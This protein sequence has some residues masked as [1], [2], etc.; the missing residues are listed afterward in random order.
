VTTTS[1]SSPATA[2]T[3]PTSVGAPF[4]QWSVRKLVAHLARNTEQAVQIGRERLRQILREHH[5]S[6]QRTRTWK[7]SR[8]PDKD[9]K[10][11][12]IDYVITHF[13][14]P[15]LRVRPVRPTVDP[16]V[17]RLH[18]GAR[19]EAA[20]VA[21]DLPHA[22][23]S[24]L[25]RLL[26][27]TCRRTRPPRSDRGR[28]Q[29]RRAVSDPDLGVVGEPDRGPVRAATHLHDG[30]VRPSQP[31]HARPRDA[32]LPAVAQRQ[33]P[34]PRRPGRATP[35]THPHPQR[36]PP[37]LGPTTRGLTPSTFMVNAL[38]EQRSARLAGRRRSE[39]ADPASSR[40]PT[41]MGSCSPRTTRPRGSRDSFAAYPAWSRS[42]C[43]GMWRLRCAACYLR[44]P[45]RGRPSRRRC[46]SGQRARR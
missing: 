34:P 46:G 11:D 32:R 18:L 29:Q 28:P 25:P 3:R 31:H 12:R 38:A 21:G 9:T 17:S 30:R 26:Q 19:V 13:L 36:T 6:F 1:P 33:R 16:A 15:V 44:T 39:R 37:T 8:D 20:A 35:R 22:W 14:E 43:Y 27:P 4:T 7:E 24:L 23:R 2:T 5:V 10:L 45:H 41:P 42:S 40:R